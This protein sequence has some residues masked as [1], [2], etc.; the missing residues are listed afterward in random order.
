MAYKIRRIGYN[1][2]D[3]IVR[4]YE[5]I[6]IVICIRKEKMFHF[7]LTNSI[8]NVNKNTSRHF[9]VVIRSRRSF[10]AGLARSVYSLNAKIEAIYRNT[11][12]IGKYY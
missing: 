5:K 9:I 7:F 4:C 10:N 3:F 1:S 2:N 11:K 8:I 12:A 6:Y